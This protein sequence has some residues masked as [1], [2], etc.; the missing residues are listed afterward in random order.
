MIR[1]LLDSSNTAMAVGIIDN[2]KI[3]AST[4]YE[5]WQ[6]QS[7]VMIPELNKL[8]DENRYN[9]KDILKYYY[10]GIQIEKI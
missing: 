6:R 7:E 5:A 1:I 10:D 8:L 3:I 9:Y 2:D 4:S